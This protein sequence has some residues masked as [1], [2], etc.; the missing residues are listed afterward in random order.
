MAFENVAVLPMDREIVLRGQT[1][2]IE[3]RRIAAIGA[4]GSV[5]IPDGTQRIDGSGQYLMP[6]LA[7]MHGHLPTDQWD[8][9]LQQ[10][11]LK[12][13]IV[14]GITTVRS[15]LGHPHQLVLRERIANEEWHGPQLFIAAPSING[16]ATPTATD[17]REQVTRYRAA[18]YDGIKIHPGLSLA[19]FDAT[20]QTAAR[21]GL[22]VGGHVPEAVGL[23]HALNSG[24]KTIEHLDGFVEATQ[25]AGTPAVASQFFG[26]NKATTIDP[27][28]I[29]PLVTAAL[30]SGTYVTPTQSLFVT[31]LGTTPPATTAARED[32]RYWPKET[33]AQ[34]QQRVEELRKSAMEG[35]ADLPAFMAFR[36]ALIQQL[37]AAG[38]PFL[39]GADAP[40]MFNVPGFAT[41]FELE[42]LVEAGLSP[43]AALQ[44]G[45]LNPALFLGLEESFGTVEV[46]KRADLILLSAN[47]LEDISNVRQRSGVMVAG[48]WYPASELNEWLAEYEN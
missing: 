25:K 36:A 16:R 24:L 44:S 17:A 5:E 30:S 14:T 9:A 31:T 38:V 13:N 8:E 7:E 26:I 12:L 33:V 48:R 32:M 4:T 18:G 3:G 46:G 40:Q 43:F 47:P 42:V 11:L 10:R 35:G 29:A 28:R 1:V 27:E 15:M 23:E 41:L 19:A 22:W 6:G 45:T 34:W 37:D 21:E 39:L 2:V 20:M